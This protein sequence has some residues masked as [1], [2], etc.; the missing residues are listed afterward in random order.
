MWPGAVDLRDGK[1]VVHDRDVTIDLALHKISD[2]QVLTF[3]DRAHTWTG[4]QLVNVSGTLSGNHAHATLA[5]L[6]GVADARI[7]TLRGN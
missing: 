1:F 2:F 4:K 3:D 6:I 7:E 5:E